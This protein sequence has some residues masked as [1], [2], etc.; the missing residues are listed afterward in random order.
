MESNLITLI[1]LVKLVLMMCV[2]PENN[3]NFIC[4]KLIKETRQNLT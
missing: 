3:Y 4:N 1:L 2:E